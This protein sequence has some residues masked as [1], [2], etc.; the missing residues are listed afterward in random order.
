M[1]CYV[2]FSNDFL[3]MWQYIV[4]KL[5]H[6]IHSS[7]NRFIILY[8]KN[9][10]SEKLEEFG[11]ELQKFTK[12]FAN[13]HNF[14]SITYGFTIACSPSMQG[15]F[16]GLPLFMP[17]LTHIWHHISGLL[18]MAVFSPIAYYNVAVATLLVILPLYHQ[19]PL[20]DEIAITS[21]PTFVI[22][23]LPPVILWLSVM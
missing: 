10:G 4:C 20:Y 16:L 6:S 8:T 12:F 7:A 2:P 17:W 3:Y 13:L 19:I 5:L 14:H 21:R 1:H 9:F 23:P 18:F 11:G 15:R 22:I